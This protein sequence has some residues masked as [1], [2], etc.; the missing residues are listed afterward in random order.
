M[1]S[2]DRIDV[3]GDGVISREEWA[4]AY[5]STP[6]R[7]SRNLSE[8]SQAWSGVTPPREEWGEPR[9][10]SVA[11][12]A[13]AVEFDSTGR[14]IPRASPTPHHPATAGGEAG[15]V[16]L[17]VRSTSGAGRSSYTPSPKKTS[18]AAKKPPQAAFKMQR[19]LDAT[20][21]ILAKIGGKLSH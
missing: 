5:G 1:A 10:H 9:F 12:T 2:F 11:S 7:E 8:T 14:E 15:P 3:N 16:S 19:R 17:R 6:S 4:T 13:G 21:T 18:F 20:S